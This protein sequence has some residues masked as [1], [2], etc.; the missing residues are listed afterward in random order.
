MKIRM[1]LTNKLRCAQHLRKTPRG[2]GRNLAVHRVALFAGCALA[3]GLVAWADEL[4]FYKAGC[5]PTEPAA[6]SSETS[7]TTAPLDS[8]SAQ[9]ATSASVAFD[10]DAAPGMIIFVR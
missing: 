5:E 1:M 6:A 3:A 10:S 9:S 2:G 8:R 4:P 7:S